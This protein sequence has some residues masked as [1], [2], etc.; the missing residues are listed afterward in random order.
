LLDALRSC[1]SV[2]FFTASRLA[3]GREL[4]AM[5][6]SCTR[7]T[8]CRSNSA[9]M[10]CLSAANEPGSCSN[11]ASIR[12]ASVCCFRKRPG[13]SSEP[14]QD[15]GPCTVRVLALDKSISSLE[16]QARGS[17]RGLGSQW[18]RQKVCRTLA[19][20]RPKHC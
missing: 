15:H 17:R 6:S 14:G 5:E 9:A 4:V 10:T 12:S 13:S 20:S 7:C 2:I 11:L 3:M 16:H 1:S 18:D 19:E 8:P